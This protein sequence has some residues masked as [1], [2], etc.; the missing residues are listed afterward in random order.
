LRP[1]R[2]ATA[3]AGKLQ[4][5]RGRH[6]PRIGRRYRKKMSSLLIAATA[7]GEEVIGTPVKAGVAS[8]TPVLT[9]A[10][11]GGGAAFAGLDVCDPDLVSG[12]P[13]PIDLALM[14]GYIHAIALAVTKRR[15]PVRHERATQTR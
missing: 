14:S 15:P 5:N 13:P 3:V 1:G 8:T 7:Q 10:R 9:A 6:R 12:D 2:S 4:I 11:V